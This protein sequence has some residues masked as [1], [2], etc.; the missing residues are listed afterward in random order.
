M[1]VVLSSLVSFDKATLPIV[2]AY[3][4]PGPIT[5]W[6]LLFLFCVGLVALYELVLA[7]LK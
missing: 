2:L 1:R 6:I 3:A 4:Y 7:S 5:P